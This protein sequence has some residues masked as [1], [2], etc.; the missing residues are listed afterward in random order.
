MSPTSFE[1]AMRYF[2]ITAQNLNKSTV[3]LDDSLRAV[4]DVLVRSHGDEI[5]VAVPPGSSTYATH[6]GPGLGSVVDAFG[7][8]KFEY[9]A[10]ESDP[11]T[12][13]LAL[14]LRYTSIEKNTETGDGVKWSNWLP[15]VPLAGFGAPQLASRRLR[16]WA[17]Q[18]L[19]YL[20]GLLAEA[21]AKEVR[22]VVAAA[23][24]AQKAED[25]SSG[26]AEERNH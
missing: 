23:N 21:M 13:Q 19:P 16:V 5:A 8:H 12:E 9:R 6:R 24:H 10:D 3:K 25:A 2:Q 1:E 4:N 26:E 20:V 17:G 18:N 15:L 7:I 22:E 14:G 11:L